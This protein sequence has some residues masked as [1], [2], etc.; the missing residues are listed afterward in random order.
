M[1]YELLEIIYLVIFSLLIV[2][3]SYKITDVCSDS[4]EYNQAGIYMHFHFPPMLS[5]VL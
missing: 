3:F 1:P 5:Q 2:H 4:E